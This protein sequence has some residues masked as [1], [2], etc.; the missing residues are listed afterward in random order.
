M[1]KKYYMP[2]EDVNDDHVVIVGLYFKSGDKVRKG[3]LLYCFETSKTVVDI[4]SLDDGYVNYFVVEGQEVE[5]GACVCEISSTKKNVLDY[6]PPRVEG[7]KEVAQPTK[8]A[9]LF[10]KKNNLNIEE[11]GLKGIIREKD[12][13]PFVSQIYQPKLKKVCIVLDRQNEFINKLFEDEG[14]RDL[15]S[16]DKIEKY[17]KNGHFFGRNIQLKKGALIIGNK[18]HI[19]DNVVIEKDTYIEAPEIHIGKNTKIGKS[20]EIVAS[21][22]NFGAYNK[23]ASNVKVDISGGRFPDSNL[24]TG[25]GCL[26]ASDVYINV[27]RE[28][29]IGK[30]V[31]LSP[32]SIV[33][34]HSY[35]QSVLDGYSSNCSPVKIEENSWIGS[36]SQILPGVIVGKGA[37]VMSGSV[38]AA[39]VQ[40]FALVGGVPAITLKKNL[41]KKYD[42]NKKFE[43]LT[44]LFHEL[45][46]WLGQQNYN[47][48]RLSHESFKI[49]SGQV[50]K[51]CYLVD[52]KKIDSSSNFSGKDI[53]I[54]LGLN[55]MDSKSIKTFFNI[56]KESVEGMVGDE[57][58]M[59]VEF[60]RRKGIRFYE[61]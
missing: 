36:V 5:V 46:D 28:V 39:N 50:E 7:S 54:S 30:N 15:S 1:S 23:I 57:E 49:I 14:F 42:A 13:I 24:E 16:D 40:P 58:L 53:I 52:E 29:L 25:L 20:C 56:S 17:R 9:L 35:W 22:V 19:E 48:E 8:K 59:I 21:V 10:A 18:I 44:D 37:I 6:I 38:V 31:A 26:I 3:E 4:E 43:I 61:I 60:F 41:N 51:H 12:L 32:R 33:Y 47:V 2:T 11:L 45:Q 27:C 55:Y 34:T